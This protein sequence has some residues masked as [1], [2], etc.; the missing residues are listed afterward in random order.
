M[1]CDLSCRERRATDSSQMGLSTAV[2]KNKKRKLRTRVTQSTGRIKK[3]NSYLVLIP[4][5]NTMFG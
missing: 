5:I 3:K 1:I 4:T 2:G